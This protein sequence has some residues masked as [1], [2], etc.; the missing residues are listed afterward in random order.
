MQSS[1]GG[2]VPRSRAEAGGFPELGSL[3]VQGLAGAGA[4]RDKADAVA[5]KHELTLCLLRLGHPAV[6]LEAVAVPNVGVERERLAGLDVQ[7]SQRGED[8]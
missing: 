6:V 5:A 4:R 8:R 7:R 1:C 2:G 3:Y